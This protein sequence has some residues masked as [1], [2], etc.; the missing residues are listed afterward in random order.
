[1]RSHAA[2]SDRFKGVAAKG[3]N[4]LADQQ[5]GDQTA[6]SSPSAEMLG[7][8]G[9]GPVKTKGGGF[10]VLA[11]ADPASTIA[12]ATMRG[13]QRG[14]R[15]CIHLTS[16]AEFP[17][18][19]FVLNLTCDPQAAGSSRSPPPI[20]MAKV[21][22]LTTNEAN[23]LLVKPLKSPG[24][25]LLRSSVLLSVC[26]VLDGVLTTRQFNAVSLDPNK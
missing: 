18:S 9:G 24:R 16:Q 4:A 11:H 6:R 26:L 22:A 7:V 20:S 25:S 17:I 23:S 15:P 10:W 2:S 19:P 14:D 8:G 12:A 5:S 21:Q 13:Q 1:M 3:V